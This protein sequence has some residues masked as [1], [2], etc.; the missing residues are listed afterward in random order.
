MVFRPK[1]GV[2]TFSSD[3]NQTIAWAQGQ[4]IDPASWMPVYQLDVNRFTNGQYPMGRA[5]RNLAILAAHNPRQ[6]SSVPSDN[7]SP[8][9]VFSNSVSDVGKIATGIAGIFTGK[10]EHQ[11]WD[12]A[13]ATFRGIEDPASLRGKTAGATLSNWINKTLL[14]FVPGAAD[15]AALVEGGPAALAEHPVISILDVMPILDEGAGIT[16]GLA[17]GQSLGAAMAAQR[18]ATGVAARMISGQDLRSAIAARTGYKSGFGQLVSQAG[19]Y[20]PKGRFAKAGVTLGGKLTQTLS[21]T[22]RIQT[23]MAA[24]GPKG[25]LGVGPALSTLNEAMQNAGALSHDHY[26]WMFSGPAEMLK[27]ADPADVELV[28]K[29]LSTFKDSQGDTYREMMDDPNVSIGAKDLARSWMNGPRRFATE[30][31]AIAGNIRPMYGNGGEL[32]M[33]SATGENAGKL[34]KAHRDMTRALR[35]AIDPDH[36]LGGLEEHAANIDT[37]GAARTGLHEQFGGQL[38][39]ARQAAYQDPAM[40]APLNRDLARPSGF[41]KRVGIDRFDQLRSV[42]G[43]NGVADAFERALEEGDPDQIRYMGEALMR[44]LSGWGVKSVD[45]AGHPELQALYVSAYQG[46]RWAE[47]Y[48]KEARSIEEAIHGRAEEAKGHAEATKA[49]TQDATALQKVRH[50]DQRDRLLHEYNTG[51]R[52]RASALAT[53]VVGIKAGVDRQVE[54]YSQVL[55]HARENADDATYRAALKTFRIKV[56]EVNRRAA[57]AMKE[58]RAKAK[59]ADKAAYT[60]YERDRSRLART[61]DT[62]RKTL[63]AQHRALKA[64]TGDLLKDVRFYADRVNKFHDAVWK[65]PADNYRD[66]FLTIFS[67]RVGELADDT[68]VK[69][70]T[71][72]FIEGHAGLGRKAR[73][74]LLSDPLLLGEYTRT[75]WND[76]L[77]QPDLDP[78]LLKDATDEMR[79]LQEDSMQELRQ[80]I[81]QGFH[82]PYMPTAGVFDERLGENNFTPIV[83]RGIPKPDIAKAKV[84]DFTAARD[85]WA[86]GINKA[87]VQTLQRDALIRLLDHH[88][89][90]LLVTQSQLA[91]FLDPAVLEA[92]A[93]TAAGRAT[94]K[95]DYATKARELGLKVLN[96]DSMFGIRMPRWGT[97][98]LYAPIPLVDALER[99][100]AQQ[101]AILAKPTKIFRYSILGLSPRYTAHVV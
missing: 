74:N 19:S 6:V 89:R 88:L 87:A 92:K 97:D 25:Y 50:K 62:E 41:R 45:A 99:L 12:S 82:V 96:P 36:G 34:R 3:W 14:T 54:M 17:R 60:V 27:N 8:T 4:G 77:R 24:L 52:Q 22:D 42:I 28:N 39:A 69:A 61:H 18:G 15:V 5:E 56:R 31:E 43:Q 33:W 85:D 20:A 94:I 13:K 76:I 64:G 10:F 7:P 11:L 51:K 79:Q 83:G 75:R 40:R 80:L 30:E 53:A 91:D 90:P 46:V 2:Q 70:A 81:G 95:Y 93:P 35:I 47:A 67:R 65:Y 100:Q 59:A 86:V 21:V 68:A 71:F 38:V 101:R 73:A 66:P 44:R 9:H 58:A 23:R 78:E 72:E 84:W 26:T 55:D 63:I 57:A 49:H 16:A 1:T 98:E 29:M 37:L 32:S 48:R